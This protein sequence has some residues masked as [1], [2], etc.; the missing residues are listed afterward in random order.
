MIRVQVKEQEEVA[1]DYFRLV[2]E[3]GDLDFE[4]QPGQ[5]VKLKAWEGKDPLLPRPFSIHDLASPFLE[6]LYQRRGVGTRALSRLRSGETLELEGPLGRPFPKPE[7]DPVWLV[8]GGVGVAPFLFYLKEL[9]KAGLKTRLF[10]GARSRKDLLRLESFKSWTSLHLA[11]EDGS[12]GRKGL[13]TDLLQ[14][15]LSR[16]EPALVLACGPRGM[17][18]A[19]TQWAKDKS[20]EVYLALETLMACGR[21]LCLG[22]VVPRRKGGYLKVCLEGPAVL[23]QEVAL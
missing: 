3:V 2:L 4:G 15:E 11:T 12:L 22:C 9:Q 21:G 7:K 1:P 20:F 23:A 8:A 14:E 10:Y 6:I 13:V 19:L 5:F 16:E 18:K 17:L